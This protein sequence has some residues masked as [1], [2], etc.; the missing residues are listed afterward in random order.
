MLG[1]FAP[2]SRLGR[3]VVA[4]AGGTAVAQITTACGMPVVT[5][6]YTPDEIGIISIFL[7]FFGLWASLLSLRYESAVIV[8]VDDTE[9]AHVFRVGGV[10]VAMMAALSAP[11]LFWLTRDKILGFAILPSWAVLISV[12]LFI[13]YGIF[14]LY[15]ALSLRRG[16]VKSI[17]R[18]AVAKSGSN[19]IIRILSGLLGGGTIGLFAAEFGGAL[20]AAIILRRAV[21]RHDKARLPMR[22]GAMHMAAMRYAKFAKYEMPSVA[23][24]QLAIMLPIPMIASLYGARA[25]GWFG[26]ARLLVAV[27]NSQIGMAVADVFQMEVASAVRERRHK[28]AYGLFRDLL[29]KLSAYGLLPLAAVMIGA[30]LFA[31]PL[32][33]K[34]WEDVGRIAAWIAPWMY[35]ALVVGSLSLVLSVLEKQEYKLI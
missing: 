18:A 29:R 9:A 17:G 6:L 24:N 5:R 1:G 23:L 13:G 14:M 19:V 16:L 15:R 34:N 26:L 11:V 20:G 28:E 10:C 32:F 4:L 22:W 2:K 30:P 31:A 27:P 8:A 3:G 21:H 35:A 33:G 25:A 7:A 12:P